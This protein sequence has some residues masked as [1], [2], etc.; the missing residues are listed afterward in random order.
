[1]APYPEQVGPE[2]I[3][4]A[5]SHRKELRTK[6]PVE[7][8]QCQSYCQ[9]RERKYNDDVCD[10]YGPSKHWHF[11]QC[12]TWRTHF[13]NRC[14]K[15]DTGHQCTNTGNLQC[16]SIVVV[17]YCRAELNARKREV[18][19]PTSIRRSADNER[20]VKQHGPCKE[21]PEADR[22]K[23]RKSNV[24]SSDLQRNYNVH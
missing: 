22:V 14:N 17:A 10:Q 7:C 1:M 20:N 19:S 2:H 11:H 5:V 16:D 3:H 23:P 4:T 6:Q 8:H 13:K 18:G 12:H 21:Q 24:T 15:V 9:Y